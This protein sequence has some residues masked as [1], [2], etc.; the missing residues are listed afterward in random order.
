MRK[1]EYSESLEDK[2]LDFPHRQ[3]NGSLRVRLQWINI[4]LHYQNI[5]NKRV[6]SY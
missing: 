5:R 2:Q 3:N 1:T 6:L 4:A